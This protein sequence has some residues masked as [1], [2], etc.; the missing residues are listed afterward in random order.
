MRNI[1]N[2]KKHIWLIAVSAIFIIISYTLILFFYNA[3]S[4]DEAYNLQVPVNLATN[5]QYA[6]NGSQFDGTP[7]LFDPFIST[8]PTLLAPIAFMFKFF[9]V[10]VW[11]YRIIT[12]I[13]Y[14]IFCILT[15]LFVMK[16][17]NN[18]RFTKIERFTFGVFAATLSIAFLNTSM[19]GSE[20]FFVIAQG[21]ALAIV[22]ALMSILLLQ[23]K[24]IY[25]A[26]FAVGLAVL[27]KFLFLLLI[28]FFLLELYYV[29]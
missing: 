23:Y 14:I 20:F 15:V 24:K 27:T 21:E 11:Q 4:F 18:P 25:W 8:G 29:L 17:T 1:F 26:A 7:K 5:G 16:A 9:G 12:F 6:S 19:V 3:I 22:F 13:I 28:P 2:T 10:G